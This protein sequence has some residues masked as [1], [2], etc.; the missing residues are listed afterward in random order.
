MPSSESARKVAR[1]ASKGGGGAKLN[2]QRNWLFPVVIVVLVG[3][4]IALVAFARGQ[5]EGVGPNDTPPR[6]R[7][8]DTS[9]FDHWHAAFAI[10]ICGDELPPLYDVGPDALGIHTHE[11]G[12]IHIHPFAT[13]AAG[14]RATLQRYFEQTG[15]TV[16]DD[17]VELPEGLAESTVYRAGETTCGGEEAEWVLAHWT[18]ANLAGTSNPDQIIRS[19]FGSVVF[20]EDLGAYTLAFVP[21]GTTDIAAPAISAQTAE[22]GAL[23]GGTT[24]Q[25]A[26][27]VGTDT[28]DPGTSE[29]ETSEP[30]GDTTTTEPEASTTTAADQ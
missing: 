26:P 1:V 13:R 27:Q 24:Q 6:A 30:E 18:D 23:D 7:L 28:T 15:L 14:K 9:P 11:D 8:N 25:N 12:L 17:A 22:L 19:D 29:P 20:T 3:M 16:T 5:N 10:N 4:G 2:K 21:V